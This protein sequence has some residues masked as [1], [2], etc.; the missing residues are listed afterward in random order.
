MWVGV[1]VGALFGCFVWVLCLGALCACV[2]C[3]CGWGVGGCALCL[4]MCVCECVCV[5]RH[6]CKELTPKSF[7]IPLEVI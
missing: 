4:C 7:K 1:D 3:V 2:L 6:F 5:E